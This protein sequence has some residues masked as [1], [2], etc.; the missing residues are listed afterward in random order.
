VESA[1][2][3]TDINARTDL[4]LADTNFPQ[5]VFAWQ[6]GR[7]RVYF[8]YTPIDYSADQ[9]VNR[10]IF[11]RGRQYT[12]GTRVVSN[13]EVQHLQLGWTYQFIHVREGRFRLGPLIQADGFLMRGA[14]AA[15]NFGFAEK[16]DLG[17][18][19]PSAGFALD[20]NPTKHVNLY[21]QVAGMKVG[22]YGYFV[23]SDSGVKVTLWRHLLLTAGYR[24]FNLHVEHAPDFARLRLRGPFAGA[25]FRF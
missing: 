10:T 8:S 12:V 3:G 5:G 21:G 17:V 22:G 9:N 18:G 2:L 7:S 1:G 6:N 24:T 23:G 16:E 15:P 13:L 14:L 20:I 4:G 19:L 25:G 11:F